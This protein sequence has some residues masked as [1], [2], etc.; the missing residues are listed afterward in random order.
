MSPSIYLIMDFVCLLDFFF[1]LFYF[2]FWG[3]SVYNVELPC[4]QMEFWLQ[5]NFFC[6]FK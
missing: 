2:F 1:P 4:D 3:I 6:Y 5:L